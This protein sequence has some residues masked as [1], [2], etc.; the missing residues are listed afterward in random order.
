MRLRSIVEQLD[1]QPQTAVENVER[2]VSG[3]Y[4]GDL[5]SATMAAGRQG[6][7]WLTV[8]AHA[9]VV[10]V[11]VLL[12]LAGVVIADGNRPDGATL[13]RANA[14]GVVLLTTTASTFEIAGRLWELG[15][16][17]GE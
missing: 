9:N 6:D 15:V 10:A 12:D 1:L 14:E 13:E 16:R 3:C 4:A 5:L 8:Q 17:A 7:L 11:A 2:E